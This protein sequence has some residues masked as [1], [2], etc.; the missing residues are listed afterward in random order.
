MMIIYKFCI[1]FIFFVNIEILFKKFL[2]LKK[3]FRRFAGHVNNFVN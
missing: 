1:V 2:G 3:L